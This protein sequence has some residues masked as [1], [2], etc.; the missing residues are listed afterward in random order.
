MVPPL[1]IV[2]S[3]VIVPVF[4]EAGM[5]VLVLIAFLLPAFRSQL[6]A[7]TAATAKATKSI[8]SKKNN[9]NSASRRKRDGSGWRRSVSS[10]FAAGERRKKSEYLLFTCSKSL[11]FVWGLVK[12]GGYVNLLIQK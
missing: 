4:A 3:L 11:E 1:I 5:D 7:A 8:V 10:L 9:I 12:L 2:P 6:D